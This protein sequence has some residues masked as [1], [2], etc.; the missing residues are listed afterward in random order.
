M[1]MQCICD[2]CGMTMPKEEIYWNIHLERRSA[3]GY[4]NTIH[5]DGDYCERC[6]L[7]IRE[8]LEFKPTHKKA[9]MCDECAH[10]ICGKCEYPSSTVDPMDCPYFEEAEE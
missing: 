2:R 6:I 5:L 9:C 10:M 3:R 8:F 1:T 4:E 7:S